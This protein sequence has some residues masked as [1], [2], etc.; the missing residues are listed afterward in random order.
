MDVQ[1]AATEGPRGRG[2]DRM[3]DG[4]RLISGSRVRLRLVG[5]D[6]LLAAIRRGDAAAFEALYDRH[7]GELL[8]FCFYMLGSRPDA[9]DALQASFVSAYRALLADGRPVTLRPWLFTIVRNECLSV[10]RK[11]RPTAELNGEVALTG[12]P[13]KRLEL[14]EEIQKMLADMRMLPERERAALVLAEVHGLSQREIGVVLGVRTEQVKAYIYQ[15]RSNLLSEKRAREVDCVEIRQE[16]ASARGAALLRGRLRRHVRSCEGCRAYADGVAHQHRQ[17]VILCPV[18]SAFALK[19]GALE[20]ALGMVSADPATAAGGAAVGM[21]AAGAAAEIAGGGIKALAV[22]LAAGAL[23]VGAGASVGASVLETRPAGPG[24]RAS[25][26]AADARS[27]ATSTDS[28]GGIANRRSSLSGAGTRG[29]RAGRYTAAL[30]KAGAPG[31]RPG[32]SGRRTREGS[33]PTTSVPGDA[34]TEPGGVGGPAI[35]SRP[36]SGAAAPA[37][38]ER[39][40][41]GGAPSAK[42]EETQRVREERA[43]EREEDQRERELRKTENESHSPAAEEEAGQEH[44]GVGVSRSPK[45]PEERR[46]KNE[47]RRRKREQR[48]LEEGEQEQTPPG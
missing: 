23:A 7:A 15:A 44:E 38:E 35:P 28:A 47:E 16:L 34:G 11:R 10:L 26:T 22:K 33:A 9:E 27:R 19:Y 8:S 45:T 32:M 20:Q 41:K 30:P 48:Q 17:L 2:N 43:R 24:V 5:D 39:Q 40:P 25:T 36:V 6:R 29:Q 3:A 31:A 21:T 1:F 37:H 42:N 46:L 13:V 4:K 18:G 14:R 12:D